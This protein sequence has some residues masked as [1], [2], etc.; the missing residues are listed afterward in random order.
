M[1]KVEKRLD[2]VYATLPVIECKGLCAESCGPI[3]LTPA[4][5]RRMREVSG[6]EPG[7]DT[8][9]LTCSLL[10]DGKCMAYQARPAICRLWGVSEVM[11]CV[12]GC[13]P[14]R[15]VSRAEGD[16]FMDR[17]NKAA[18]RKGYLITLKT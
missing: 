11:P 6:L 17:V 1:R 14:S 16:R 15:H 12:F 9:T 3:A 7:C 5:W 18:G 8:E 10:K 4:E 13:K 2:A